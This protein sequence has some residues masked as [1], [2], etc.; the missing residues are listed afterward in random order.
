MLG[1]VYSLLLLPLLLVPLPLLPTTTTTLTNTILPLSLLPLL[2][3]QVGA[4]A[5]YTVVVG[6]KPSAAQYFVNDHE[7]VPVQY[8]AS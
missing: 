7:E 2:L 6:Q 5:V 8:L 4:P 3:L 1:L